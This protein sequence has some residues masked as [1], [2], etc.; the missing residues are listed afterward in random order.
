M[1]KARLNGTDIYFEDYGP[2]EAPAIVFSPLLYI[3]MSVYKPLLELFND[4][5]RV[6]TYD[7][8]GQG[9][10]ARNTKKSDLQTSTKDTIALIEYLNLEPCHFVGNCLGAFVGLNLAVQRSDLLKSCTLMGA[11]PEGATTKE[12]KDM[13]NYLDNLKKEGPRLGMQSFVNRVFGETFRT[14]MD[15]SVIER[16]EKILQ[17]LK[18]MSVDELENARQI[19][20]RQ[21]ISKEDLQKISVPVLIIAGDED[22]PEYLASYKRLGLAIPHVTYKTLHHAGYSLVVEQ[23]YE[24]AHL[25]RDHIEKAE[26]NYAAMLSSGKKSKGKPSRLRS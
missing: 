12:A 13:D 3:D 26:R 2:K 18:V 23:P 11:V 22:V 15:P 25:V 4:E 19:F 5:F 17:H 9:Q 24:V 21:T 7:H 20:H 6:V 16:R 10:S 14:S 1:P 8:R